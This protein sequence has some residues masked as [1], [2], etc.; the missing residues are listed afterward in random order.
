MGRTARRGGLSCAQKEP[1]VLIER[2]EGDPGEKRAKGK[3]RIVPLLQKRG[4]ENLGGIQKTRKRGVNGRVNE[5]RKLR[6]FSAS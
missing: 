4:L 3:S 6:R 5:G 2:K 1:T